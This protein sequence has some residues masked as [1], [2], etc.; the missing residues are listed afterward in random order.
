MILGC[1]DSFQFAC[2]QYLQ[3]LSLHPCDFFSYSYSFLARL[4][5][6]VKEKVM[7]EVMVRETEMKKFRTHNRSVQQK[8]LLILYTKFGVMPVKTSKIELL[9]EG[10]W[11]ECTKTPHRLKPS[12]F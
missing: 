10:G 4:Q 2:F 8:P 3:A 11:P 5:S 7:G 9:Q 1:I 12:Q 6:G